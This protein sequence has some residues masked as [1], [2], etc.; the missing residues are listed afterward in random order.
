MP[1][2]RIEAKPTPALP[3]PAPGVALPMRAVNSSLV[4]TL[5]ISANSG[6]SGFA[7]SFSTV[8]SSMN[9]A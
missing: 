6:A 5:R 2:G 9:D 8:A 1:I 3:R 4:L 7:S